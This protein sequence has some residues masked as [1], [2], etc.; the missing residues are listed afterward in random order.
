MIEPGL[1]SELV[2]HLH[3]EAVRAVHESVAT[4]LTYLFG[5]MSCPKCCVRFK[6]ADE[7]TRSSSG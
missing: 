1:S 7:M 5:R 4:T 6:V 3:A 2:T